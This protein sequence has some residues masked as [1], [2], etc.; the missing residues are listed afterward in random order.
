MKTIE[1]K[2]EVQYTAEKIKLWIHSSEGETV[3]RYDIRFGM[4]IHNSLEEQVNGKSQCLHCTH[5]KPNWND[6]EL[7]C[8]KAKILWRV[9]ID[10]SQIKKH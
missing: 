9:N 6:F 2:Y 5:G 4:D 1:S 8:E 7:F 3:G 10:K